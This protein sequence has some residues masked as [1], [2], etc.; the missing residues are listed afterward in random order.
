LLEDTVQYE[1]FEEVPFA[2]NLTVRVFNISNAAEVTNG[3]VPVLKE[4]GPYIYK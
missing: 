1:R 2:L 3:A 4:L